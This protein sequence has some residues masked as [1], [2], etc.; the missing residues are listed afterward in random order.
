MVVVAMI[1]LSVSL[2]ATPTVGSLAPD[3]RAL[4]TDGTQVHLD[5]LVKAGPVVVAFFPKAFTSG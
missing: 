2:A 4:D 5:A 3:I 1:A